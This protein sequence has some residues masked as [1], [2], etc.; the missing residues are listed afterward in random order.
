MLFCMKSCTNCKAVKRS[1][2]TAGLVLKFNMADIRKE[3][4]IISD[5]LDEIYVQRMNNYNDKSNCELSFETDR[6][7]WDTK[8][9]LLTEMIMEQK[10]NVC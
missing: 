8:R 6:R 9:Q 4:R 5:E 2:S 1:G 7:I 10:V 3:I